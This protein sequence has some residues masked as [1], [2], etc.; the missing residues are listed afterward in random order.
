MTNT[1]YHWV[2]INSVAGVCVMLLVG[3]VSAVCV[4]FAI[5]MFIMPVVER[6]PLSVVMGK[7]NAQF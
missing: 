7:H 4:M 3:I 1:Y 2:I 6:E 5:P